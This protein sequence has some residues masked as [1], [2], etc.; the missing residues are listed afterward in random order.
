MS[1]VL[2]VIAPTVFRDEEYALPREILI[3]AGADV[4][5][6]STEPG[7]CIGKLGMTA[8]ATLALDDADPDDY[9]AILF[10]GGAGASVFF[11]D[12]V[13]HALAK[14]AMEDMRVVGAICVAPSI[15]ARAGLLEGKRATAFRSQERD[16]VE[17][18]AVWTGEP[19]TVSSR[20]ITANG[21]E[22]ASE[23]GRA[24]AHALGMAA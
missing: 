22:A 8:E 21:P 5:T 15:L 3:K 18:G 19:V 11:D 1:K 4:V 17:H 12:P 13:A 7:E 23:F 6:A 24:V 16:L 2:M 20:V 14:H 10:V 9:D